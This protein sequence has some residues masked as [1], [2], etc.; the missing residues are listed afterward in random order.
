M[1]DLNYQSKYSSLPFE[2][3]LRIYRTSMVTNSLDDKQYNRILEIGP[4]I[5]PLFLNFK[6][7][8]ELILI[9]PG[10]LFYETCRKKISEE[11]CKNVLIF[12]QTLEDSLQQLLHLEYDVIIIG[13]FLHEV[14]NAKEILAIIKQLSKS[15]TK[16][17]TYVPNAN[18]FHRLLAMYSGLISSQFEFSENDIKFSRTVVFDKSSISILFNECGFKILNVE[19]YFLKLFPHLQM[20]RLI[21]DKVLNQEVLFGLSNIIKEFPDFGCEIFVEAS[22]K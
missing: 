19:S 18:S 17:L 3:V 7:Y 12:N 16:I 14:T 5:N 4:G 21:R 9:E 13:G 8:K 15:V 6:N 20:D 10:V 22:I 2:D 1:V 11:G